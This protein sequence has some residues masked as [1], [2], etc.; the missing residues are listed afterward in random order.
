MP[1]KKVK[2][3]ITKLI[4]PIL[5]KFFQFLRI[6]TRVI[7]FLKQKKEGA[8]DSYNFENSGL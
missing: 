1:F 8:N 7:N 2:I 5:H 6:N 4:L 3:S